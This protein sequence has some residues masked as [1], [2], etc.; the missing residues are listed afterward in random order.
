MRVIQFRKSNFGIRNADL[1]H[2]HEPKSKF[3]QAR[4]GSSFGE[5]GSLMK[6]KVV[7]QKIL[8]KMAMMERL[9]MPNGSMASS[10]K[11]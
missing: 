7:R 4:F 8:P 9:L 5:Y 2:F 6:V 10:T 3:C 11:P 1:H